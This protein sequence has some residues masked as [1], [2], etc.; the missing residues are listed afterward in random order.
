LTRPLEIGEA[1][2]VRW[3][4]WWLLVLTVVSREE[5]AKE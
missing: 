5:H 3:L 4:F 2:I 1:K